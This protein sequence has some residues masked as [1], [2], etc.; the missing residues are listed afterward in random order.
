M[1]IGIDAR[2]ILHPETKDAVGIGHYTYQMIRHLLEIDQ[3]NTYVLFFDVYTREKDVRRFMSPRVKIVFFPFSK[4][5]KFFPGLYNEIIT[6]AVLTRENLDILHVLSASMRIPISY[7]GKVV[8]TIHD[9]GIYKHPENYKKIHVARAKTV[10]RFMMRRADY[11]IASSESIKKEI[12]ENFAYEKDYIST[13]YAGIDKRFFAQPKKNESKVPRRFGITKKYVLFLGTIHPIKNITRLLHAF[14]IFKERR[15]ALS[16]KEGG[17]YQL[18]IVGRPGW[19]YSDITNFVS[20]LDLSRDVKF[21]GYVIGDEIVPL[22]HE[23]E[24]FIQPALYEGLGMS[25]MEA[26][27]TGTPVIA[28]NAGSLPEIMDEAGIIINPLDTH[29]IA[30]AFEKLASSKELRE[31]YREQGKKRAKDFT[32]EEAARKTLAIY[33]KIAQ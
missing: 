6:A 20:D 21:A 11:V 18:L 27:A 30:Q 23:A 13:I 9:L 12:V 8:T 16:T 1:K 25:T 19:L 2:M 31:K 24:F 14:Q 29:E 15:R 4:Y 5:M 33:K 26:F 22:F 28:S 17:E 3:E 32:W 7:S 10:I